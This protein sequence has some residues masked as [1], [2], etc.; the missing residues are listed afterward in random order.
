MRAAANTAPAAAKIAALSILAFG[1]STAPSTES[2]PVKPAAVQRLAV[3][4][5]KPATIRALPEPKQPAGPSPYT[6]ELAMGDR[7]L[8]ER[9][10]P[11]VDEASRRFGVP[12]IWIRAV[13]M[14]ESGGRT[15]LGE[16]QPITSS[17]GAMGLM[18]VMPQTWGQ[19]QRQYGL[20]A[21]P[22]DPHDNVLAGTA[23]LSLLY[24]QYGY[25]GLFAAYNDGPG[26]LEAH[27]RLR[28]ML[29]AETMA[30]VLDIASILSTGVRY[31]PGAT[32]VAAAPVAQD[33]PADTATAT[34]PPPRAAA[35][36]G[37]EDSD[38]R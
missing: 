34:P 38:D 12:A 36:D 25:P 3:A 10:N 17:A 6:R 20:G 37:D 2:P 16:N 24:R 1:L 26:Q 18:Q 8:L 9:W 14:V 19:M 31:K 27:L 30:Y 4:Q 29:P 32:D 21:D 13:M 22:Y 15:M 5:P 23:Y 33:I 35:D 11:Y 28:E 7:N